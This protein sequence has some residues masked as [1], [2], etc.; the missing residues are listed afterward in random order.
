[1]TCEN[2][3][4]WEYIEPSEGQFDFGPA[5]QIVAW[6]KQNGMKIKG[7]TFVWHSQLA[8][9]VKSI[10]DATR[11]RQVI[12]N[13]IDALVQQYPNL[14]AWDV[15][16]EA[17]WTDNG[18][19]DTGEGTPSMR[20]T[21]F[22]DTLGENY[23]DE[24]FEYARQKAPGSKLFY[25][26]YSIDA[27]NPK[28]EYVYEM[29]RGMVDRGVPIDGVGLQMHIGPPN[30]SMVSYETVS[31]NMKRFTDLGL[32]VVISEMD[33]N[34]CGDIISAEKQEELYHDVVKA[35]FDNIKCTAVTIWGLNDEKSWLNKWDG[36]LCNDSN[37]QSL[38]FSNNQKK[39]NVYNQVLNALLG[40]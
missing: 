33:I 21:V 32:E 25:N 38:L 14:Y 40:K 15:I 39:E 19:D 12:H 28:A 26:D 37:S 34:R 13:H 20:R 29:I 16:N 3:M 23:L 36:S 9:W 7:H 31:K 17:V 24:I 18:N 35:C 11:M 30:N 10:N 5:D 27:D 6:A 1:V 8:E 22:H 4:K 2:E